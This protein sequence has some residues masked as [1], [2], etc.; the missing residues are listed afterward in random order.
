MIVTAMIV[1]AMTITAIAVTALTVT[2]IIITSRFWPVE[3]SV[4][5]VILLASQLAVCKSHWSGS[6]L[7]L[8]V[9]GCCCAR[10]SKVFCNS[11]FASHI[12]VAASTLLCVAVPHVVP[13]S[14]AAY[15]LQI[16]FDEFLL[17]LALFIF[18]LNLVSKGFKILL[19]VALALGSG[20]GAGFEPETER[21]KWS[22]SE[23]RRDEMSWEEL[24]R[25]EIG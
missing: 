9:A 2:A 22:E 13:R 6:V 7:L 4:L 23:L 8:Y 19:F 3:A 12:G 15:C 18:P 5:N 16:A 20:F 17:I 10:S 11:V 14:F 25:T 24:R 1:T 21:L